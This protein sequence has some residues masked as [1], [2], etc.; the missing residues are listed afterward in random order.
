M[1][2]PCNAERN[3]CG[4]GTLPS[5]P[6][7][8]SRRTKKKQQGIEIRKEIKRTERKQRKKN[9]GGGGQRYS[10]RPDM[11]LANYLVFYMHDCYMLFA[12]V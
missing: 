6:D 5:Q 7:Y 9:A 8:V 2:W 12:N 10:G 4:C 3:E 1:I 11:D